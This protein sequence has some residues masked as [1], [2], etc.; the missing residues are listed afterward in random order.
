MPHA[1]LS[2]IHGNIIALEAIWKSIQNK[3]ISNIYNLGD[4]LNGPLWPEETAQFLIQNN[5]YSIL[6]NGDE[7]LIKGNAKIANKTIEWLK[8]LD[9]CFTNTDL[10]LFHGS[11]N[12]TRKY[13]IEKIEKGNVIIKSK[14]ELLSEIK[15]I[16]SKYICC[17]HS[18]VERIIHLNNQVIINVGS[19]GLPAYS[20]D[21]PFHCMETFNSYAKYVIIENN[22]IQVVN[23]KYDFI[24]AA[25]QAKKNKREDWYNWIKEGRCT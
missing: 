6:G 3:N 22:E 5:I 12:N 8:S 13:L 21:E 16:K 18:H 23:V 25:K 9:Y 17:G 11:F 14:T 20:D 4:S 19:V 7:D 1:L 24:K 10:T 15:E 2:D